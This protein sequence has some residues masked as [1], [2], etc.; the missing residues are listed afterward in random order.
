MRERRHWY[1]LELDWL[2]RMVDRRLKD[3]PEGLELRQAAEEE[4]RLLE[5]FDTVS[6]AEGL[7]RHRMGATLWLLMDGD[8]PALACWVFAGHL[9]LPTVPAGWL[10]LPDGVAALEDIAI[11]GSYRGR[12]LAPR[13]LARIA[14]HYA[15]RGVESLVVGVQENDAPAL[16]F[17]EKA[18]F[19]HVGLMRT[20]RVGPYHRV[21]LDPSPRRAPHWLVSALL[22]FEQPPAGFTPE[23][24]PADLPEP[25]R[26]SPHVGAGAR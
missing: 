12:G 4:L 11:G 21:Y 6:P 14:D 25:V 26:T 10:E 3:L 1:E 23:P 20:R 17:V 19:E 16:H 7:L 13:V 2:E 15:A 18:G 24:M 5:E 22:G 9:P 8:R